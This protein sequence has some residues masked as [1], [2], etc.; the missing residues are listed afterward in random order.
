MSLNTR[1]SI[2]AKAGVVFCINVLTL[3]C[4]LVE[5]IEILL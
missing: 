4:R 5:I 3:I 2:A 1:F